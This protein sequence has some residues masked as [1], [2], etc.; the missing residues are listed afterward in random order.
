MGCFVTSTIEFEGKS[1]QEAVQ[2]A[3][4]ALNLSEKE[5]DY[6]V[7]DE[8]SGGL[9]G[10]GSRPVRI[11]ARTPSESAGATDKE[12]RRVTVERP[13]ENPAETVSQGGGEGEEDDI[14]GG[15]VGPAP[16]KAARALEV[17]KGLAEK[18]GMDAEISVR[19]E[20]ERIVIV[21]G[22][23]DGSTSV[24]EILGASRPPAI[25]SFQFLLNKIVNRFP[26]GRKHILVEVPSVP[27]RVPERK[28]RPAAPPKEI[29]P[30]LDPEL[31]DVGR[32]LAARALAIGKVITVHPMLP[33]DRRAVHQTITGIEGVRTMSEGE[34][35]YRRMH[36]VPSSL[37]GAGGEGG[38][39]KRRRRRRRRGR[40]PDG[41]GGPET[42]R[43]N[44]GGAAEDG[45]LGDGGNSGGGEG[46]GDEAG[47]GD[48]AT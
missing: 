48:T 19:D 13:S 30:D 7:V 20:N 27:R 3:C 12:N 23:R 42:D 4:N 9:F 22:E 10:L 26:E 18:M 1:E 17:A 46:G 16:E 31:V 25:P 6:T 39:G 32:L 41:A 2:K 35:L 24:A 38:L 29:D 34:G 37:Q 14:R 40:R 11:R 43:V 33:G 36:V 15:V 8:G 45:D 28:P 5:L 47:P 21:I 44:Q